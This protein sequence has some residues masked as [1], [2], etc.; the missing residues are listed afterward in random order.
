MSNWMKRRIPSENIRVFIRQFAAA[1]CRVGNLRILR[2]ESQGLL[3]FLVCVSVLF[4]LATS[5]GAGDFDFLLSSGKLI[6]AQTIVEQFEAGESQVKV[7]VNLAEPVQM[8]ARTDWDSAASVCLLGGE[9]ASR[10]KP[11]LSSLPCN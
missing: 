11:V 4:V 5:A 7:I 10:Q 8:K 1:N 9:I 2:K 3:R 6:D